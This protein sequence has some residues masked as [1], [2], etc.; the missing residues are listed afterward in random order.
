MSYL[1]SM[2]FLLGGAP[3]LAPLP[4]GR[5]CLAE[6]L[7]ANSGEKKIPLGLF[8]MVVDVRQRGRATYVEFT[9]SMPDSRQRLQAQGQGIPQRNGTV[10][11]SF[12]DG[13]G[14][15]GAAALTR[16]GTITLTLTRDAPSPLSRNIGRNY[17]TYHVT[18]KACAQ[19]G[20]QGWRRLR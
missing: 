14:N 12:V 8:W 9:N 3:A 7:I 6:D 1:L 16:N 15:H 19:H 2:A 20:L 5:Y 4:P 17:G 13:W 11:F 10:K 18:R